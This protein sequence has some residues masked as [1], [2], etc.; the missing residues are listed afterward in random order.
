MSKDRFPLREDFSFQCHFFMT[1]FSIDDTIKYAIIWLLKKVYCRFLNAFVCPLQL[2]EDND[3]GKIPFQNHRINS[4]ATKYLLRLLWLLECVGL[5]PGQTFC[6][7]ISLL[8]RPSAAHFF[9]L[10]TFC[11][12][13]FHFA[14]LLNT[15]SNI[16]WYF[17]CM[18]IDIATEMCALANKCKTI[19]CKQF[20]RDY[21]WS[22]EV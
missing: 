2:V 4:S 17:N 18:F 12:S 10:Q 20:E 8:C 22:K 3:I 19:Q 16:N 11:C 14:D 15:F 7:S 5:N 21:C 1:H 6:C 9:T 13:L